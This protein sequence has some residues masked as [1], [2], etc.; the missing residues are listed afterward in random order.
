MPGSSKAKDLSL[1]AAFAAMMAAGAFI[2]IPIYPVPLSMQTFFLYLS[3]LVLKEKAVLSQATYL[4]MGLFGL[5][6]FAK[7]MGGYATLLG[8]TGGFLVGFL[9]AA[10]ASGGFLSKAVHIKHAEIVS[11][12]ICIAIVFFFGWIWLSY[13]MGGNTQIAL[14]F[15]VLQFLPGD[16]LKGALAIGIYKKIRL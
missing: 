14:F 9:I 11:I 10:L 7:G 8:P 13:W 1:A 16:F 2:T 12:I 6:V 3:V 15:G 4:L 5:P